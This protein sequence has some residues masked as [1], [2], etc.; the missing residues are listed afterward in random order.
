MHSLRPA[1]MLSASSTAASCKPFMPAGG[2]GR[3]AWYDAVS[4]L[5]RGGGGATVASLLRQA[6]EDYPL[7]ADLWHFA[8][9]RP[10]VE[11]SP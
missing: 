5:R 7:N 6:R 8:G 3:T 2:S 4:L 11:P 10:A 9:Q 1:A